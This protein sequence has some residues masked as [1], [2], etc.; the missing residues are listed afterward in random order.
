MVTI[1][2]SK[3]TPKPL[4]ET[5]SY[6][7]GQTVVSLPSIPDGTV[8]MVMQVESQAIRVKFNANTGVTYGVTLGK[9][10]LFAVNDVNNPVYIFEGRDLLDRMRLRCNVTTSDAT[11]NIMFLGENAI[12]SYNG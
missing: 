5:Y 1:Y 2:A 8:A 11:V 3:F 10:F 9:G 6:T 4:G 7:V 12:P